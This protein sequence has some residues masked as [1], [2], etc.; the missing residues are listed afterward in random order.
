[1]TSSFDWPRRNFTTDPPDNCGRFWAGGGTRLAGPREEKTS[2]RSKK[3]KGKGDKSV[4]E[5]MAGNGLRRELQN[6]NFIQWCNTLGN[7]RRI[8]KLPVGGYCSCL[9]LSLSFV[10]FPRQKRIFPSYLRISLSFHLSFFLSFFLSSLF[11]PTLFLSLSLFPGRVVE[12]SLLDYPFSTR[13]TASP[14]RECLR[15]APRWSIKQPALHG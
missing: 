8:T 15:F 12:I 14:Y 13:W 7:T 6:R 4:E 10:P 3:E 5:G 9:S 1:M 2:D 11:I